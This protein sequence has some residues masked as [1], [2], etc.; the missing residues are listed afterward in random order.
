MN[1]YE[2]LMTTNP[3]RLVIVMQPAVQGE[4]F[5]WA[6]MGNGGIPSLSLIGSLAKV[7]ADLDLSR[8]EPCHACSDVALVIA[9]DEGK[10]QAEW[11]VHPSIPS[12]PLLGMIEVVKQMVL[13]P[14]L[15]QQM[16]NMA[17]QK[18]PALLGPNGMPMKRF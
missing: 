5:G 16:Q 7:Q 9:W 15:Q 12:E 13:L 14:I 18:G 3:P 10:K 1:E 4:Q 11:F 6:M 2:K 17:R 8:N